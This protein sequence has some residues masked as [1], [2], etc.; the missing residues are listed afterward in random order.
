[1]TTTNRPYATASAADRCRCGCSGATSYTVRVEAGWV[2]V[3]RWGSAGAPTTMRVHGPA[4][5]VLADSSDEALAL[6]C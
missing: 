5:A 2:R 4:G 3:C 6:L 1:M